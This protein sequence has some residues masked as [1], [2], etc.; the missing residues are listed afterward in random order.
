MFASQSGDW[1]KH[2]F[3]HLVPGSYVPE[4]SAHDT[5]LEQ[6]DYARPKPTNGGYDTN[7]LEISW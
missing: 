1:Q 7:M 3:V 5:F 6:S 2:S 4:H